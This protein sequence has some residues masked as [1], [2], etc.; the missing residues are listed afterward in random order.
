MVDF[1]TFQS[2]A[3]L[4]LLYTSLSHVLSRKKFLKC[5]IIIVLSIE[6]EWLD[7][8]KYIHVYGKRLVFLSNVLKL[9]LDKQENMHFKHCWYAKEHFKGVFF[10]TYK[11]SY[12]KNI[13]RICNKNTHVYGYTKHISIMQIQR[14]ILRGIS[15]VNITRFNFNR[16]YDD[17]GVQ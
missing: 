6:Y 11:W 13:L 16:S 17:R 10:F 2:L 15:Y 4:H 7:I 3:Q 9:H 8:Y 12:F 14:V 1:I 5:I